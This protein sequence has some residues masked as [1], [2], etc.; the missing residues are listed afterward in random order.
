MT[1]EHPV[2]RV[3]RPRECNNATNPEKWH[4]D[5]THGA[6]GAQQTSLKALALLALSRNNQ[7][8]NDATDTA[9]GVQRREP[10]VARVATPKALNNATT[11]FEPIRLRLLALADAECVDSVLVH[12][13]PDADLFE[14]HGLPS[15]TLRAYVRA[16]GDSE[17]REHGKVPADETAH[18]LC[19]SC[20]PVWLNP[21]VVAVATVVDG[22]PR[23]LGCPWCHVRNRVAIPR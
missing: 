16:L 11:G 7:C 17:L 22:W 19:R 3:A 14:C 10:A 15:E 9:T 23:V 5:A 8:N 6:T 1:S 18:A 13:L 4:S 2:L 12:R 20:G 21:Q